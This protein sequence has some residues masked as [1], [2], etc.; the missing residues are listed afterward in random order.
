[1]RPESAHRR[2]VIV[3]A[4]ARAIAQRGFHGM[5]MRELARETG[6]A[7]A[8]FYNHFPSKQA[9]LFHIQKS[10]FEEMIASAEDALREVVAPRHRLSAFIAQHVRYVAAHPETMRVL[11]HEAGTLPPR[12]RVQVR[13]LKERYYDLGRAI[14]AELRPEADPRELEHLSYGLFGM[15]NWIYGWY[16]PS[17]HGTPDEVARSLDHIAL[18]GIE[19]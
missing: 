1:M 16:E 2:A 7:L 8:G 13:R 18:R 4:A 12:E 10:A 3:D 5:S 11:V 6:H 17:R 9:V 19:A 15:L 14:V